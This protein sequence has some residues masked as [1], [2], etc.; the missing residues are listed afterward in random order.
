MSPGELMIAGLKLM[1]MGMGTVFVFL[2]ILIV[3]LKL[4][5]GF[6]NRFEDDQI[7]TAD[8]AAQPMAAADSGS[9]L[10]AVMTAAISRFRSARN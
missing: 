7:V 2:T 8:R 3:S 6:A 5:S 1:F 9:E 4:M 10:I